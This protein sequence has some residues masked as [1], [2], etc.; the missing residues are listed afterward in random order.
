MDWFYWTFE[1]EDS[2]CKIKTE[3]EFRKQFP[4]AI[5]AIEKAFVHKFSTAKRDDYSFSRLDRPNSSD[6]HHRV[7]F[8]PKQK[9]KGEWQISPVAFD[10][11]FRR[12]QRLLNMSGNQATVQI[13]E[14]WEVIPPFPMESGGKWG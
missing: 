14:W 13:A 1:R 10:V 3:D 7:V 5:E 4:E 9:M 2:P 8:E 6:A 11:Y 12:S